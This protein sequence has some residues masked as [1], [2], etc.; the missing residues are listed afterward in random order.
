MLLN[1]HPVTHSNSVKVVEEIVSLFTLRALPCAQWRHI[2]AHT[3]RSN[4][5]TKLIWFSPPLSS[6]NLFHG[7]LLLPLESLI[8]LQIISNTDVLFKIILIQNFLNVSFVVHQVPKKNCI[9]LTWHT[10]MDDT[11]RIWENRFEENWDL[12]FKKYWIWWKV[13]FWK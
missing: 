2:V 12:N 11:S 6:E 1:I 5:T 4:T 3:V 7:C 9:S 8:L 10:V 13:P